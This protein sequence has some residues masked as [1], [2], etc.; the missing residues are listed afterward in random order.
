M[1]AVNVFADPLHTYWLIKADC[2]RLHDLHAGR[3]LFSEA[4]SATYIDT[5]SHIFSHQSFLSVS[6]TCLVMSQS[7]SFVYVIMHTSAG[8]IGDVIL[9]CDRLSYVDTTDLSSGSGDNF[10]MLLRFKETRYNSVEEEVGIVF[11]VPLSMIVIRTRGRD[12]N[13][14]GPLLRLVA[15]E[16][17]VDF[18]VAE[19]SI[20]WWVLSS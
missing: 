1:P 13:I 2:A 5:V 8:D 16:N 4:E 14:H 20:R 7:G 18:Q 3:I 19:T 9:D 6:T 15:I 10:S 11:T 12:G 17:R